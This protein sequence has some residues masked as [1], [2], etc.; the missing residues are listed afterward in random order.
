MYNYTDQ[1]ENQDFSEFLENQ[2]FRSK[3]KSILDSRV[4]SASQSVSK[5]NA[6]NI[7]QL[8]ELSDQ[9][10]N[11]DVAPQREQY[12][13]FE[14]YRIPASLN[15]PWAVSK[16]LIQTKGKLS[17]KD[18]RSSTKSSLKLSAQAKVLINQW[19]IYIA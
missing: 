7:K 8:R 12:V 3:S 2:S 16:V 1:Y 11:K 4:V 19:V 15:T 10:M 6:L 5:P 17:I 18:L 9:L 14:G 13:D